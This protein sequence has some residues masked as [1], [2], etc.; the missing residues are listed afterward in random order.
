MGLL[1]YFQLFLFLQ[2][3]SSVLK[4]QLYKKQSIIYMFCLKPLKLN[5]YGDYGF[6]LNSLI[7]IFYWCVINLQMV[8][9]F[10]TGVNSPHVELNELSSL[11]EETKSL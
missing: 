5:F 10:S 3:F 1:D 2:V 9:A 11:G 6:F 4:I 8:T 7:L